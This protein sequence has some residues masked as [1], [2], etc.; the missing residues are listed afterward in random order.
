MGLR[1]IELA[2]SSEVGNLGSG[3]DVAPEPGGL[4]WEQFSVTNW[5]SWALKWGST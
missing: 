2:L 3:A 4:H 1:R 5:N